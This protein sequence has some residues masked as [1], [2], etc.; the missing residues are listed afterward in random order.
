M[1][2]DYRRPPVVEI[3]AAVQFVPL[4][5]FGMREAVELSRAFEGWELVDVVP[6][7]EPIVESPGATAVQPG[8]KFGLGSPPVRVILQSADRRWLVQVQQDR[9]AAHERKIDERPS[10]KNVGEKL[11]EVTE[12]ASTA[13]GTEI[14]ASPNAPEIVEVIYENQIQAGEG[15]QDFG[16]I[17]KVLQLFR[18]RAGDA[19]FDKIEQLQ[20]GFAYELPAEGD[21]FAGRLRVIVDPRIAPDDRRYLHLRLISRRIVGE[22]ALA[23]VLEQCH[24]DIVRGFTAVTTPNMHEIWERFQ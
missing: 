11:T 18:E 19:P 17:N 4:P 3:V 21:R 9:I 13:L 24:A 23:L 1:L 10:F 14:L 16:E 20:A 8:L 5:H 2:P 6:A 22:D 12:L 15:W 7:L